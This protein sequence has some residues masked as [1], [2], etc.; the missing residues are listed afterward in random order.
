MVILAGFLHLVDRKKELIL[1][2][3]FN[4]F[5]NEIEG[6]V[7]K[8]TGVLESPAIGIED[9][10]TGEKVKLFV[11]LKDHSITIETIKNHCKNY[12]TA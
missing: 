3:S 4:V 8:L 9:K 2:S 10:K 6:G 7:S 11:V 1:V 5:P 12:L